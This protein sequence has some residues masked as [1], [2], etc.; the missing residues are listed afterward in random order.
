[1]SDAKEVE[2]GRSL[3]R[4]VEEKFNV[5]E[6]YTIQSRVDAIGQKLVAVSDRREL[7]YYF[8]VLNEEE[9]NAF[10]LPGGY[11]YI[12]KGLI[13][14]FSNDDE[15]AYVLA[16]ELSH[17]VARHSINRLKK[18]LGYNILMVLAKA[19]AADN[20]TVNRA[21]TAL[22]LLMLSY[23]REDELMADRLAVRF[24]K[25]AG[26]NA[27]ASLSFLEKLKEIKRREPIRPK[28]A[29]THPY[30]NERIKVVKEELYG[31]SGFEEYINIP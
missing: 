28:S 18:N 8:K 1:M 12:F 17:I 3:S 29:Q 10:A 25:R 19:G 6:D 23:S 11:I 20:Q 21:N 22:S 9:K 27:Q 16:H 4:Q 2:I 5:L 7:I 15:L 26:F 14:E 13:D 30:I 24:T 31:K